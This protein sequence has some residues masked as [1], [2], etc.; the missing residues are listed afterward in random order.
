MVF[1]TIPKNT[2]T[3]INNQMLQVLFF[4]YTNAVASAMAIKTIHA[5]LNKCHASNL[6]FVNGIILAVRQ[7][8]AGF[9]KFGF[10]LLKI[11]LW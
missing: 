4:E 2:T 1:Q 10:N 6:Y 9:Q 3:K 8:T 7:L 5:L 11:L